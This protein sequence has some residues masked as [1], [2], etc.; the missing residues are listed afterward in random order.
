M[1][2][3]DNNV[4][5]NTLL[6]NSRWDIVH[7][8]SKNHASATAIAEHIGTSIPNVTQQ[9]KL[10]EAYDIVTYTKEQ[11]GV[12]KPRRLYTLKRPV[13]HLTFATSGMAQQKFFHPGKYQ[14]FIISTTFIKNPEEQCCLL[15]FLL[16]NEELLEK[17]AIAYV[18]SS[19]EEMEV[20]LLTD[21]TDDIRK[22]Y[23]NNTV[24]ACGKKMQIVAWTHS[25]YEVQDGLTKNDKHFEHLLKDSLI[26]HDPDN[27][28]AEVLT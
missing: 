25:T 7:A 8:I 5:H 13:A 26:I 10:L 6:Q 21:E 9:L 27:K 11:N 4:G 3:V 2:S 18:R 20:F 22:K 16:D 28:L 15:K 14:T 19:A 1:R 12:G 17:C 23:S 24:E